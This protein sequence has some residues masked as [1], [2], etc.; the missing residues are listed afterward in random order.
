MRGQ[1]GPS[2]TEIKAVKD[3]EQVLDSD[4]TIVCGKPFIFLWFLCYFGSLEFIRIHDY[5]ASILKSY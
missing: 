5:K 2:A 1:A 4:D 3:F